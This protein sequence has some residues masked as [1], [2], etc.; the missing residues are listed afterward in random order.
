VLIPNQ[1]PRIGQPF[2]VT[3]SNLPLHQPGTVYIGFSRTSWGVILL[4][5]DLNPLGLQGCR[6][7]LS[8]ELGFGIASTGP[9][10]VLPFGFTLPNDP[11]LVGVEFFNQAFLLDLGANPGGLVT[12]N[13]GHGVVGS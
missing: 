1:P 8:L 10:G 2:S 11:N 4:P 3:L 6:L 13:A 7:F 5:L 9:F 12:T